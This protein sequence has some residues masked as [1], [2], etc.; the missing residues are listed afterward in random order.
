MLRAAGCEPRPLFA[1]SS[2]GLRWARKAR[3]YKNLVGGSHHLE[4]PAL[5]VFLNVPPPIICT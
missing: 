4:L 2:G 1:G 3:E 5:E